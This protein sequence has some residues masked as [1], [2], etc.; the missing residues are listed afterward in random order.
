[1]RIAER[2]SEDHGHNPAAAVRALSRIQENPANY[3][4]NK[5]RAGVNYRT[6]SVRKSKKKA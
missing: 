4:V 2:I 1:M 5:K 6:K 3:F